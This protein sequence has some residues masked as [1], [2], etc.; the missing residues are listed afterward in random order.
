VIE[1]SS[2][3]W[4]KANNHRFRPLGLPFV[5]PTFLPEMI[6]RGTTGGAQELYS[7]EQLAELD[8]VLLDKLEHLGSDFPYRE[9]FGL[10]SVPE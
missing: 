6:R 4:M 9:R 2:L 5:N 1:R 10:S 8:R 3:Q 7:R